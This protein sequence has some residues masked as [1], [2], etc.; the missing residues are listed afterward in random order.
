MPRAAWLWSPEL[1]V[2]RCVGQSPD[3]DCSK[4]IRSPPE[5]GTYVPLLSWGGGPYL[6]PG[7]FL[8]AVLRV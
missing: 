4:W 3:V 7:F 6:D 1:K 5:L 8:D 2:L